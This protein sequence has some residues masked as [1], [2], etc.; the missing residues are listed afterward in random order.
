MLK[1]LDFE[2]A[3]DLFVGSGCVVYMLKSMDRRVIASNF[4][5]LPAVLAK[6]ALENSHRHLDG[7]ALRYPGTKEGAI[8][9]GGRSC[10]LHA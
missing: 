2:T 4:L 3:A 7:P 10:C 6:A 5:N 9:S 8:D 1:T